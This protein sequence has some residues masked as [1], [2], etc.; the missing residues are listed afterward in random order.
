MLDKIRQKRMS[1]LKGSVLGILLWILIGYVLLPTLKTVFLSFQ[2]SEGLTFEHYSAFFGIEANINSLKNTIVLGLGTVLVC[3]VIGSTLAF[4]T[5]YFDFPLKK[6]FSKLLLTPMMVPGIIIVL[7][8]IQ[9]YGEN[10]IITKGLE[11]I[12]G[13]EKAPFRLS[14]LG[15]ILFIHGYTQYVYFYIN[16]SLAIKHMDYSVIEAAKNLG[17]Q[18]MQIFTSILFPFIKPA[19]I[20]S[21][22]ITFITGIGSFTAPSLIGDGYKVLT[23][24]MLF[25]KSNNRMDI[26]SVQVVLLTLVAMVFLFLCRYYEKKS[27]FAQPIKGVPMQVIQI[28]N[29]FMKGIF[30]AFSFLMIGFILLPI[31]A[32]LILS[33]VTPHTWLVDI[34][35]KSYS[36]S[37]YIKIFTKP[38]TFAPFFN[39]ISMS[40]IAV[41]MGTTLSV[42]SSYII[43][44][45]KSRCKGIIEALAMLPLGIPASAIAIHLINTFNTPN[46]FAFNQIL[47]GTYMLLPIAYCIG[48]LPLVLRSVTLSMYSLNDAYEEASLSLG[49]N[50][51]QGFRRITLPLIKPGI[52]SG[53]AL[54]F[55]KCV[56]EYTSSA[57]LYTAQNKPVSI[58]MLSGVFEY[59]IGLAMAYGVLVI[60]ITTLLSFTQS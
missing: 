48:I 60:V 25:A 26:A 27:A 46:L 22:L 56:G 59:E 17:A 13:L 53:A 3:G 15:G 38:R 47:V 55:I 36:L 51:W 6:V 16:V 18:P 50:F 24:Q 41:A 7:A 9:L 29:K 21:S 28:Q 34:F 52:V 31:V 45:T 2:G 11:W 1:I 35:P 4:M 19:L 49:G 30:F 23:T 57:Y 5:S 58:A 43:V 8:F 12:M 20:A 10:G 33:F 42:A 14:G 39:S 44:K 32:I 40:F 54:G 37:N